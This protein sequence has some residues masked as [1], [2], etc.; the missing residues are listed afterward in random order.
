MW[1]WL[2]CVT[3]PP[4]PPIRPRPTPDPARGVV[5]VS[6]DTTRR[7][8]L[9]AYGARPLLTPAIDAFAETALVFEQAR[10]AAPWT[11]PAMA[12]VMTNLLPPDHGV[13]QWEHALSEDAW[14]LAESLQAEGIVTEAY[15]SHSAFDPDD[16]RFHQGFDAF[17]TTWKEQE[18]TGYPGDI[19]TSTHL[20]DRAVEAYERLAA[21]PGR[22]FLWVHY[23]DP[24]DE[25]LAHDG[26]RDF[27]DAP[28]RRYAGEI[29]WTDRH[30]GRLLDATAAD[31]D[32][33]VV[34]FADHGEEFG[35]HGGAGHAHTV[36][37]E[38]VRVPLLIRAPGVRP[39]RTRDAVGTVDLAP[40]VHE[41]FAAPPPAAFP[42]VSVFDGP[43]PV[44]HE[45]RRTA[46]LRAVTEWPYKL[47]WDVAEGSTV[48]FDLSSDPEERRDRSGADPEAR[49]R[50]GARLRAEYP[51]A[52]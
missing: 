47:V 20:T 14:T 34:V 42:G 12:S 11:K 28:D 10:A 49:A 6:L 19:E 36:F 40:T 17:A 24:H 46:D 18:I 44:F 39:G 51:D 37:D 45:T 5:F 43:R 2:A 15:V 13:T 52:P 31:E 21:D 27:G 1:W 48:L 50:L 23:F 30:L 29:A 26:G 22:F 4:D 8:H 25:Y 3:D 32:V 38:L 7:D 16:N 35:D 33:A 9:G 41:L